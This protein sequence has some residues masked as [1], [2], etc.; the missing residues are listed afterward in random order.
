M[1][2]RNWSNGLF[3][4]CVAIL[5]LEAAASGADVAGLPN[6]VLVFADDL[7]YADVGC[8]G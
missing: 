7:G 6:I 4:S 3:L 8:C 2:P 5:L 1:F